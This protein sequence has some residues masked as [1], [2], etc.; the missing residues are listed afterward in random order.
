M[1][2]LSTKHLFYTIFL[3]AATNLQA[4]YQPLKNQKKTQASF[5]ISLEMRSLEKQ[6]LELGTRYQEEAPY[7]LHHEDRKKTLQAQLQD[8]C[9][10]SYSLF[11]DSLQQEIKTMSI[12]EIVS[13]IS[14]LRFHSWLTERA[15]ECERTGERPRFRA[16]PRNNIRFN[17]E[18]GEYNRRLR[19]LGLSEISTDQI[20]FL[21]TLDTDNDEFKIEI[22]KIETS[23]ATRLQGYVGL[24]S[25]YAIKLNALAEEYFYRKKQ[26][27]S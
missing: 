26:E 16:P 4:V 8:L 24:L 11:I 14:R 27:Q 19:D 7:N 25:K 2:P 13:E 17:L 3:L 10:K 21:L 1:S 12:S 9:L 22:E 20:D 6:L 23:L 15:I 5:W 18:Y